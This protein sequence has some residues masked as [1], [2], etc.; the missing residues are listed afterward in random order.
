MNIHASKRYE[1]VRIPRSSVKTAGYNPR[2]I[3]TEARAKLK[4]LIVKKGLV[5]PLI[6]NKRTGN[7]VGGHQRLSIIDEIEG[8]TDYLL[9]VAQIDVDARAERELNISLNSTEAMGEFD[10]QKLDVVLKELRDTGGIDSAALALDIK[11][12]PQPNKKSEKKQK[13]E[14]LQLVAADKNAGRTLKIIFKDNEQFEKFLVES[15]FAKE[16]PAKFFFDTLGCDF[17]TVTE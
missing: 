2:K 6:W 17:E 7:L 4:H 11:L 9:E 3:S 10:S 12:T 1:I 16:V 8:G 13:D 14:S 15:G 5:T